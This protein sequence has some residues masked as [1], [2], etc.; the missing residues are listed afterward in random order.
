MLLS[1]PMRSPRLSKLTSYGLPVS[2]RMFTRAVRAVTVQPTKGGIVGWLNQLRANQASSAASATQRLSL[3]PSSRP[4]V[5]QSHLGGGGGPPLSA[6]YGGVR[7]WSQ[8]ERCWH[9][10]R[11]LSSFASR[12]HIQHRA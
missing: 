1:C 11:H 8:L 5:G 9:A 7:T 3:L 10:N 6:L 2:Y 12:A 4:E